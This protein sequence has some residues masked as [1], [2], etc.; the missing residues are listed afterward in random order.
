MELPLGSRGRVIVGDLLGFGCVA[1]LLVAIHVFV[2]AWLQAAFAFQQ[3]LTRPET[4]LT[5]AYIHVDDQHLFNNL[6]GYAATVLYTYI[7]SVAAG[8][9]RW[10]WLTTLTLLVVGPVL[11]N[12]TSMA[13]WRLADVGGLPPSRGFSGVVAGFGGFLAVALLIS[14]RQAYSRLTVVYVGQF[15]VLVILGELLVIYATP[16]PVVGGPLVVVAIG[17]VAVGIGRHAHPEGLPQDRSEWVSL[18]GA[19]LEVGLVMLLLSVLVY[20]L[21]P[22]VLVT[23]GSLTN[24]FAHLSGLVWGAVVSRWGYRYWR[25]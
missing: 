15:V 20:G 9:R 1:A 8:E 5:A 25:A 21:F 13:L 24:V 22:V 4:L 23:D 17:L 7:L 18:L 16:A 3:S 19:V 2:P 11:V 14:L 12:L 6:A 10:F